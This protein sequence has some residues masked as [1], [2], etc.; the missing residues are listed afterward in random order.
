MKFGNLINLLSASLTLLYTLLFYILFSK[1]EG[2]FLQ[3]EILLSH[4]R[5]MWESSQEEFLPAK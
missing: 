5:L 4:S 3:Y 2:G 1:R